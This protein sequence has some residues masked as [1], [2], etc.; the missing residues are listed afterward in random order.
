MLCHVAKIQTDS[1]LDLYLE[2]GETRPGRVL[3]TA[4]RDA[5]AAGRLP[6]GRRLPPTRSLA[7]D[8]GIARVTVSDV[9]AQLTAEG[10]LEARVGS[11]TWVA[12]SANARRADAGPVPRAVPARPTA[13]R[14]LT[15]M[16][17]GLPDPSRFP[18][19]EWLAASRRAVDSATIAELGYPDPRGA[20]RLRGE[21]AAYLSRTRGV[22]ADP[23]RTLIGHGFGSL[24]SLICRSLAAR[25]ARRV[26]VEAY[27]QPEH[28]DIARA[29]GLELVS[30]P[31]DEDGAEVEN[32]SRDGRL[33]A[34]GVDAVL[35]TAS[36]QFP[37]GVPLSPARRRQVVSWARST[38][39]IVLE[40]DYD[41]EFRFDRRAVGA[42]QGMAPDQVVYLGTASK[43]L[44]PGIGLAWAVV[45][46]DLLGP[47]LRQRA[48][49][50]QPNDTL[51]QAILAEFFAVHAYDRHARRMRTEYRR[52]R[53]L[54]VAQLTTRVP[55]AR[56]TG[57]AAGLQCV[58]MLPGDADPENVVAEGLRRGLSFRTLADY[59]ADPGRPHPPAIVLGYSASPAAR[60]RADIGLAVEAIEAGTAARAV[61]DSRT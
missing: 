46:E 21:L 8:L 19:R 25:G 47:L 2:L 29:A 20:Q 52:R 17:A 6:V 41:G 54:L 14:Q 57:V 33:A 61:H 35:L 15:P 51:N 5:I 16:Y 4:L 32:G 22:Q 31:V 53:E 55:R 26:A 58:V 3:E 50:D 44:A 37:L 11:G 56:V 45:P 39:G 13:G 24:L 49:L 42:L 40:D 1:G 18:R 23:G 10:W 30:L 34:A 43:A 28:R 38:G 7:A 36:H 12:D 48:V 60:A 9:Y 59:A 27:G